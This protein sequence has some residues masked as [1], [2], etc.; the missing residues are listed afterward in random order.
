MILVVDA[1]NLIYKFPE[2]ETLMYESNLKGARI[3]LLELLTEFKSRK[4][5]V[6]LYV[7]FDGKKDIGNEVRVDNYGEL[8]VFY[9]HEEKADTL[10]KQFIKENINPSSLNVITSDKEIIFFCKRFGAK[11]EKSEDF[12]KRVNQVLAEPK[13]N[14]PSKKEEAVL[15]ENEVRYWYNLFNQK[16]RKT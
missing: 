15:S 6:K 8:K 14:I 10:I 5:K 3:G 11:I 9:S 16:K 7:F 4:G 12:A 2:L 1:F 13:N